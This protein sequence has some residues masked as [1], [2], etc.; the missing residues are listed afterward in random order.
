MASTTSENRKRNEKKSTE[1][2]EAHFVSRVTVILTRVMC[3]RVCVCVCVCVCVRACVRVFV[4]MCAPACA[5]IQLQTARLFRT[6]DPHQYSEVDTEGRHH[7][8]MNLSLLG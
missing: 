3:V 4:K 6:I 7:Q 8:Q 2:E 1:Q 5:R